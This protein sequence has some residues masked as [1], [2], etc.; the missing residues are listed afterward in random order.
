LNPVKV[1]KG[2]RAKK[3]YGQHFLYNEQTAQRIV[4]AVES[5]ASGLALLEIGPG[6]GVLTK[7]FWEKYEDF[8]AVEADLDMI[9][10][11]NE[12]FPGIEDKLIFKDF[13]K[14][15]FRNVFPGKEMIL[16]GNFPY[17]ISS[18]ILIRMLEQKDRVPYLVG[19]F[20]KEMADRVIAPPGSK[21]YGRISVMVQAFY[22]GKMLFHVP[23][24]SFAPPPKVNSAVIR[25]DRLERTELGCDERLFKQ[26]VAQAFSMR[27]KMLRN[28]LKAFIPDNEIL[29]T[30][31]FSR[32]PETLSVE[33]FVDLTNLIS[34]YRQNEP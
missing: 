19:M 2:L 18:Q 21:V 13:L 1:L 17:N 16:F 27:R 9:E 28:T 7:Y 26:V 24:G 29:Q 20:Q 30:D 25:L 8:L 3:S 10:A 4:Q 33:E 5:L 15:D 34:K 14:L 6:K 31:V 11:L 23:P 22:K 32:R 12:I